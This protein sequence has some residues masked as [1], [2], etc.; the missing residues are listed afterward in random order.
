ML[1]AEVASS[2]FTKQ[3]LRGFAAC[4]T[5]FGAG[6]A[7]LRRWLRGAHYA[8]E[9]DRDSRRV[10]QDACATVMTLIVKI[11]STYRARHADFDT[12]PLLSGELACTCSYAKP[13]NPH[14]LSARLVHIWISSKCGHARGRALHC[15]YRF[16]IGS[17]S[18][19]RRTI[20]AG[21]LGQWEG[22]LR[23]VLQF[24]RCA[25]QTFVLSTIIAIASLL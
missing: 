3:R 14:P 1:S 10:L 12:A 23:S 20:P 13:N 22:N 8:R 7:V 21:Y 16:T 24:R 5:V 15:A 2:M 17:R 25:D 18:P 11:I 4:K 19:S 6:I 9:R